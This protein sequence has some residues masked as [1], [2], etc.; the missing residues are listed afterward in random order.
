MK[1]VNAETEKRGASANLLRECNL[2]SG[3]GA[4][5]ISMMLNAACVSQ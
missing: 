1:A 5:H 3:S 4:S 2:M